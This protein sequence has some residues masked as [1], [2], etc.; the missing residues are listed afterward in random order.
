MFSDRLLRLLRNKHSSLFSG[1]TN[2]K[3]KKFDHI[4]SRQVD[5]ILNALAL[6]TNIRLG[7]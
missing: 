1:S 4:G 6:P 7:C 3:E 5:I 2:Y